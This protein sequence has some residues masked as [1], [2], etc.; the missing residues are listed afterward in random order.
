MTL[1][2]LLTEALKEPED[3]PVGAVADTWLLSGVATHEIHAITAAFWLEQKKLWVRAT[4][5]V[6]EEYERFY[7]TTPHILDSDGVPKG[8]VSL[9]RI[10]QNVITSIAERKFTE[11]DNAVVANQRLSSTD[12]LVALEARKVAERYGRCYL[13]TND[14]ELI[15]RS[16]Q[17]FGRVIE[18]QGLNIILVMPSYI[19]EHLSHVLPKMDFGFLVKSPVLAALYRFGT[20]QQKYE[21]QPYIRML[22]AQPYTLGK[23]TII[24]DVAAE[25][26]STEPGK[27]VPARTNE[28]GIPIIVTKDPSQGE[29]EKAVL[30]LKPQVPRKLTGFRFAVLP[31]S[32]KYLPMF[33]RLIKEKN[34]GEIVASYEPIR[35]ARI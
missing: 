22:R 11:Q 13:I 5:N 12:R 24:T 10:L 8:P 27:K 28:Y 30:S 9:E 20:D 14:T 26:S 25:V 23:T 18:E 21:G 1:R 3:I 16:G 33:F 29:V 2:D 32:E 17:R 34:N 35:W 31:E 6:Q 15:G 4:W 7:R 19:K